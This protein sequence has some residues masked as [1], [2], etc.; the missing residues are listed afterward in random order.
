LGGNGFPFAT[1]S[2]ISKGIRW[3]ERGLELNS[4]SKKP[5]IWLRLLILSALIGGATW[6]LYET[7]VIGFF[8]DK[9]KLLHLLNS[10]KPWDVVLFVLLQAA[11]VIVAPIPGEVTGLAGGYLYGPIMGVIWSTLGLSIGSYVAFLLGR[12]FGR[13]AVERFVPKQTMARFD[14]LLA[15]KGAVIVFLLFLI[16]GFPKDTLCWFLG[17]GHLSVVEF[18]VISTAGRLLGTIMLTLG[19]D[20]IRHHQYGRFYVLVGVALVVV[21]LAM[22][23]RDKLERLFRR[24]HLKSFQ[25]KKEQ[26]PSGRESL[27]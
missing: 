27:D 4:S 8:L 20:F 26:P 18:L 25:K 15:H 13:P 6:V 23:Y 2:G 14:Y 3:G 12:V 10:M 5:R 16:P 21:L 1:G 24:W 17:L 11:Q 19:G 22:A 9:K 7:G